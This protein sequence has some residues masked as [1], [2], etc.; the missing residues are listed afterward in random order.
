MKIFENYS[1]LSH[2]T[3]G[4]DAK[5]RRFIEYS[6]VE[7]LCEVL[8]YLC[9]NGPSRFLHIGGGSNLL[10]TKDYDGT[11]LHSAIMGKECVREEDNEVF[12]CVGAGEDWDGFVAWCVDH[13]YFG[14][15]NLSYIPGEVGAS[16][17]QNIGAYG[18]EVCDFIDSVETI[19]VET[20]E[21]RIFKSEEC[22]YAY[23]HSTFKSE[24][25]G[26]YIVTHVVYRLSRQFQPDLKYAALSREIE[27]RHLDVNSLTAGLL[28]KVVV[29]V[30]Q[31]K[32]PE[33]SE[34]G[35][36]GSFFMNPVVEQSVADKLLADY[37]DMPHYQV[38]NGVKVPAGWLIDQCGWKGKRMGCAGVYEK[39]ALVLVN[40]GGATGEDICQLS[41]AVQH[42]VK[43]KFGIS[44]YP[45]VN[46]I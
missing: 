20:G 40:H 16:A 21:Q 32:L 35:S 6:T 8:R 34:I 7:D 45:E 3:F 18:K 33:P 25:K 39:Q 43:A 9:K 46:F 44:I 31:S 13:G 10:F 4:I 17:V 12:L 24:N 5:C 30:R 19:A 26:K 28:R 11:V 29:E 37:P 36:A 1:L 23:R 14:L 27:N 38:E 42:D 22:H 41:K 15:E 2:N